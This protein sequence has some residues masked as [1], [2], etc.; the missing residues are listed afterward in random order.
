MEVC[1]VQIRGVPFQLP[2][3]LGNPAVH[4]RGCILKFPLLGTNI[5]KALLGIFES[6]IFRISRLVGYGRTV[7][8]LG[9]IELKKKSAK[10]VRLFFRSCCE[11]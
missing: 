2:D 1:L 11:A 3:F 7:S 10:N 5:S 8:R 6:M 9:E 4:F